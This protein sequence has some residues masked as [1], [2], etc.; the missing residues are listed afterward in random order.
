MSELDGRTVVITG[1]G[2]GIGRAF[3]EGF[4]AEGAAVVATDILEARLAPLAEAGAI[5]AVTDVSDDSQVR[6]MIDLAVERTG[7]IDVLFNNAGYGTRTHIEDLPDGEFEKLIA[8]HLFGTIYGMRAALP[9]MRAQ[10]HGR[11]I[12]IVSRA[13]EGRQAGNSAYSAA[14]AAMYAVTRNAALEVGDHDILINSLFPGMTNTSIWGVDMPGMQDPDDVYPHARTLATL[15]AGGP[16]G[17]CFYRGEPY[18]MF[19]DNAE[20]MA[21]DRAEVKQRLRDKGLW[22]NR[23]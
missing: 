13:A 14:K 19:G 5:T 8:V 16:N 11:I 3:A 1:A 12:N 20:L 23:S 7:R 15:P 22:E 9:H 4:L 17:D 18:E 6:A 10:N 21:A 2:A